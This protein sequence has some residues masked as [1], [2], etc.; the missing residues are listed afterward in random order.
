MVGGM[1]CPDCGGVVGATETT[2]DGD[3]CRCFAGKGQSSTDSHDGPGDTHVDS[4]TAPSVPV[5][6]ICRICGK[7]VTGR[8]RVKSHVGYACYECDKEEEKRL[9]YGR[10]RCQACGHLVKEENLQ[11]YEA[12]RI[13][14]TCH[15]EKVEAKKQQLARMGFKGARTRYESKQIMVLLAI[16]AVLGVVI[17]IGMRMHGHH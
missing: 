3:P 1:L 9:N 11:L 14:P 12:K 5:A 7:D 17:Y 6:K 4:H 2:E 13:C 10:V 8:K 15:T 16:L